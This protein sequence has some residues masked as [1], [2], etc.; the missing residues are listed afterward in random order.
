MAKPLIKWG[1]SL[2]QKGWTGLNNAAITSFNSNIINSF[3]REM[4]QNSNDARQRDKS[5][6]TVKPLEI[7]INYKSVA[8]SELPDFEGLNNIFNWVKNSPENSDHEKFFANA[9]ESISNPADIKLFIFEDFNTTGLQGSDDDNRST[10]SSCVL[11]EGTSFKPSNQAGGSFGIGKN[12]IF[13]FSKLRTVFYISKNLA[14]Q[15]IFQGVSKL[16]TYKDADGYNRSGRIFCGKTDKLLSIRNFADMPSNCHSLFKRE[17][18]GLTQIALCPIIHDNWL[19]EFVKAI[20]KNYWLLLDKG[21]LK[22]TLK[23]N[24]NTM[25]VIFRDNLKELL[26]KYFDPKIFTGDD[27]VNPIGNPFDYYRC[28]KEGSLEKRT[29]GKLGETH[30]YTLELEH[31]NTNSIAF[32]RNDMVVFTKPARG[33]STLKYCGIVI[34]ND[35][36]GNAILRDM[37]PHTHDEFM[38]GR[39][40]DSKLGVTVNQ[41]K[42]IITNINRFIKECLEKIAAKYTKPVEDI[43][44]LNELMASFTGINGSGKGGRTNTIADQ[45]TTQRMGAE[46]EASIKIGSKESSSTPVYSKGGPLA[47]TG[48]NNPVPGPGTRVKKRPK[49]GKAPGKRPRTENNVKVR[50]YITGRYQVINGVRHSEYIVVL[51][52]DGPSSTDTFILQQHADSGETACFKIGNIQTSSGDPISFAE[53]MDSSGEVSGFQMNNVPIPSRLSIFVHEASKSSFVITPK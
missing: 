12:A 49:P 40:E 14:D 26:N 16:A 42:E 37:E 3:I 1:S 30:C 31:V 23:Q 24:D 35:Q 25:L 50:S 36:E 52:T 9:A 10:F 5:G 22:V 19:E 11:S 39:L 8:S 18:T 44:W 28:Y 53:I 20:L 48:V 17:Q 29:L 51:T 47:G 27:A 33:F 45:E 4:F 46:L 38:P 43:P 15:Y 2:E 6:K 34:C 7:V 32:L 21:D 41:G 13:G